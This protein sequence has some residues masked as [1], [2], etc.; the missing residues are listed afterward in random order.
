MQRVNAVLVVSVQPRYIDQARRFLGLERRV[1]DATARAWHAYY[2]R[3]GQSTDLEALLQR[4]LTPGHISATPALPGGT[5][6]GAEP[7]R[8]TGGFGSR[9]GGY[10]GLA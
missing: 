9:T 8:M 5:A 7:L 6:P 4:A 3:N 2:V 10:P 1:E